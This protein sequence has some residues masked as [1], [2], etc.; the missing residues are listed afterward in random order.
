MPS[1]INQD[2]RTWS[3]EGCFGLSGQ[4]RLHWGGKILA[5][6]WVVI[7]INVSNKSIPGRENITCK[8][9]E[10]GMSLGVHGTGG[11]AEVGLGRWGLRWGRGAEV[12]REAS[13]CDEPSRFGEEVE[14][15]VFW[16]QWE[17]GRSPWAGVLTWSDVFECHHG[18]WMNNRL[19]GEFLF[20]R[21]AW[22][23]LMERCGVFP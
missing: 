19:C 13:D 15:I 10:V 23:P 8:G 16:A 7:I 2:S 3:V 20:T 17:D 22:K 5:K 6:I 12:K 1:R 18:C 14:G 21:G 4:G 9:P 11:W